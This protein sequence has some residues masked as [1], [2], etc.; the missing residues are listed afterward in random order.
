M[1]NLNGRLKRVEVLTL[2]APPADD[3]GPIP[4]YCTEAWPP[5]VR[6]EYEAA[7]AL[8]DVARQDDVVERMTGA[9]P[10]PLR[11]GAP[12]VGGIQIRMIEVACPSPD[13]ADWCPDAD[14]PPRPFAE[15]G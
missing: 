9:R 6:A 12:A 1:S 5:E 7:E 8:G 3:W 4:I 15:V 2:P 13:G 11:P 10:L 14:A